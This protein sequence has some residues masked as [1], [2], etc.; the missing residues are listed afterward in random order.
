MGALPA[1]ATD[2]RRRLNHPK[3]CL[4]HF[5]QSGRGFAGARK[6]STPFRHEISGL[7]CCKSEPQTRIEPHSL[8]M[9]AR[10]A[11]SR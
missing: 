8:P 7:G 6:S 3:P 9:G 4:L 10:A 11:A 5:P 2:W 1:N